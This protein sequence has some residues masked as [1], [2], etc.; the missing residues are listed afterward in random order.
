MRS[1]VLLLSLSLTS[2]AMAKSGVRSITMKDCESIY[3]NAM[4]DLAKKIHLYD[5]GRINETDL[6]RMN[7]NIRLG[8]TYKKMKCQKAFGDSYLKVKQSDC[9]ID[10][11][12]TYSKLEKNAYLGKRE[13][14]NIL[15]K[16]ARASKSS[17]RN[18]A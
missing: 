10:Q 17:C 13:N 2:L 14:I 12:R 11:A 5:A 3:S 1:I 16:Q 4:T 15:L 9:N 8:L 18:K 6:K 7:K